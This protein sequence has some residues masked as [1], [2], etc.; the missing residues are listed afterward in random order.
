MI[1]RIYGRELPDMQDW[2][3]TLLDEA[4]RCKVQFGVLVL[5]QGMVTA[6]LLRATPAAKIALVRVT[7]DPRGWMADVDYPAEMRY[8]SE[9]RQSTNGFSLMRPERRNAATVQ[10][11][12][13][14]LARAKSEAQGD[15]TETASGAAPRR[16]SAPVSR[17]AAGAVTGSP[18]RILRFANPQAR[19]A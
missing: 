12:R 14:L 2:T 17:S 5:G 11:A 4:I 13:R 18:K 8:I 10:A 6:Q 9:I 7:N 16:A 1:D 19:R 15:R 3:Q